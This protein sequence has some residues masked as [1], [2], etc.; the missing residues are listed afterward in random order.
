VVKRKTFFRSRWGV[1]LVKRKSLHSKG[2]KT[3]TGENALPKVVKRREVNAPQITGRKEMH[4]ALLSV[5]G[6]LVG[7]GERQL[8]ETSRD[9]GA[10]KGKR[11]QNVTQDELH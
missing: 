2:K 1:D 5:G 11:K 9:D 6:K 10:T 7:P 3:T 8:T 4:S